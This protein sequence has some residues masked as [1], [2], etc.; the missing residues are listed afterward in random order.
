MKPSAA[1]ASIAELGARLRDGEFDA[2]GLLEIFAGRI[3]LLG[4]RSKAFISLDLERAR[5]RAAAIGNALDDSRPL[6]GIPYACKDLFDVRGIATTAGSRVLADNVAR[7]DAAAI[8]S[9]D[10]AGAIFVGKNNLHE[11]A[12][13][14]TGENELYGTA[15]NPWDDSRLAGGSSSGSAAAVGYGLCAAAL[16]T[17]TGGSV[18]AP[19]ALCGLVGFKPTFGRIPT[20][21]VIPYS[22]SLDHVGTFTRS[23]TD[24]G[25]LF[26]AMARDYSACETVALRELRIGMPEGFFFERCD[27][28]ILDSVDRLARFLQDSGATLIPVGMPS[29]EFT[30]SVSLAV[31]MPEALSYHNRYLEQRGH[32]YSADFRAGL[33]LGQCLLAE[34]Y[35]RALRFVESYRREMQSL[36]A[37]VDLL[38]T[39]GTPVVAPRIG[40]TEI[41]T[42]GHGEPAGNAITRYTSF[43]NM[44]G[45]P[46]ITFPCGRHGSGLPIAAQLVGRHYAD[47]A[48]LA[49]TALIERDYDFRLPPPPLP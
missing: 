41:T 33:A 47:E 12:Y 49:T 40:V 32:L 14:A 39:P 35:I 4:E 15:P 11:F 25:L 20:E 6:L 43:F 17:D 22:W 28:E 34:Q 8:E 10:R 16:G 24:A 48:L 46:A 30:R 26:A 3:A 21:G 36:F 9:L 1:F 13:G 23:A 18:R 45:N 27:G 7:R 38:L 31:Q 29:M 44:T 37:R 42:D 5:E 19:A 2:P